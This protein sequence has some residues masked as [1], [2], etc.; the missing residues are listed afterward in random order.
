MRPVAAEVDQDIDSVVPHEVCGGVIRKRCDIPPVDRKAAKP[1]RVGIGD[2]SI[3]VAVRLE[4][5]P[6]MM[7][8]ERQGEKDLWIGTEIA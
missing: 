8:D 5:A 1:Q 7:A 3:R 2:R 4:P 6:V